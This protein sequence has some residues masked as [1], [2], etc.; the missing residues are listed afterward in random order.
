MQCVLIAG[1][2]HGHPHAKVKYDEGEKTEKR[3]DVV[4]MTTSRKE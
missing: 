1:C 4:S 3:E 2:H